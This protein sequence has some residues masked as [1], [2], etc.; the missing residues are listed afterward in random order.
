MANYQKFEEIDYANTFAKRINVMHQLVSDN[1]KDLI[2]ENKKVI[3]IGGGPAIGAKIIDKYDNKV[4]L[5]NIEPSKNVDEIPKLENI[6]YSTLQLTF[7]EAL[8]EKLPFQA[9]LFLMI[10]AAHEISLA[11]GKTNHENKET[12]LNDLKQFCVNNGNED[13]LLVIGFPNYKPNVTS[14]EVEEQRKFVDLVMGHSHPPE[15]FFTVQEFNDSFDSEPI[16]FQQTP[17]TLTGQTKN[18]TKLVA[19][20]VVYKV[21]HIK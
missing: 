5:L 14:L 3:D 18:E 1:L 16:F 11:N 15:E 10:S 21:K 6:D 12:F 4:T 17:M 7:K 13:S 2:G 20:F 9:D 19:N 8:K